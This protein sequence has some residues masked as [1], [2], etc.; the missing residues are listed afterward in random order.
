[1][2]PFEG[3]R[4][5]DL[6]TIIAG[7]M[8]GAFLGDMGADVVKVERGQGDSIRVNKQTEIIYIEFNR[9]KRGISLDY[10]TPRGLDALLRMAAQADVLVENSRPGVAERRGYG[11]DTLREINPR[12]IYCAISAYGQSG[13]YSQRPAND[14]IIQGVSGLMSWTGEEGG[15]PLRIGPALAD[16][17]GG[18]DGIA[19]VLTALYMRQV[20]GV[21][22]R[23]DVS[24][25]NSSL[26]M[27]GQRLMHYPLYGEPL[28]PAGNKHPWGSPAEAYKTEDGTIHVVV[29][30]AW[31]WPKFCNVIGRPDMISDPRFRDNRCRLDNR[32][33]MNAILEPIFAQKTSQEWIDLLGTIKWS[34]SARAFPRCST[35]H[36]FNTTRSW[37]TWSTPDTPTFRWWTPRFGCQA[38]RAVSAGAHRCWASTPRR[39]LPSTDSSRTRSARLSETEP[40][41]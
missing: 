5:L 7:P 22:Q 37:S 4:V 28:R 1:M 14:W 30:D 18:M 9:S 17:A 27:V 26:Y 23:V 41:R 29:Q 32:T 35:I 10:K 20:S 33:E 39:S 24:L 3:L 2:K 31:R 36:R 19:G 15:E 34:A 13:P 12:L 11:Y 8:V 25:L 38:L 6:T 16:Y 40:L 21:G